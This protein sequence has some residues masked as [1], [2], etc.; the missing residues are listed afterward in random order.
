MN[1]FAEV[2]M[3]AVLIVWADVAP[4]SYAIDVRAGVMIDV[5][6]VI[7]IDIVGPGIGVDVLAGMIAN[8]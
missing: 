7:V 4:A 2:R 1:M 3:I 6:A 8:T 5:L